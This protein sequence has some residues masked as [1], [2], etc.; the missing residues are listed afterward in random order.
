MSIVLWNTAMSRDGFIAGPEDAMDQDFRFTAS[1][2]N[3]DEVSIDLQTT[4][5][6][7]FG[8]VTY[9]RF[10]VVKQRRP[11]QCPSRAREQSTDDRRAAP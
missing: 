1:G 9:L 3:S 7:Q 2:E 4:S 10:T 6:T 11:L 8:Q 5:V